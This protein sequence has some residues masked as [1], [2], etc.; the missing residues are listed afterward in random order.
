MTVSAPT[1][2]L[3]LGCGILQNEI[4]FLIE[5]NG[6][7]LETHF[8]NSALHIDFDK[9]SLALT[10]ALKRHAGA[11]DDRLLRCLSSADGEDS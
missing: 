10:S 11:R 5:K 7:P 6:W 3:L 9:L 2:P 4:R 8:L 1:R